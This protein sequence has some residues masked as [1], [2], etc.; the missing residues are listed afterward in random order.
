MRD[1]ERAALAQT[2]LD[3]PEFDAAFADIEAGIVDRWKATGIADTEGQQYLKLML[4]IHQDYKS[5]LKR[6][7]TE[8][9][10]EEIRIER[11]SKLKGLF[12]R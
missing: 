11:E 12:R 5:T 8:G 7:I 9:K 2:I 3:N 6:R 1:A 4:K 10:V